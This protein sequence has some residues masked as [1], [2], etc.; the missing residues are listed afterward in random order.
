MLL[1]DKCVICLEDFKDPIATTCNHK[2]CRGCIEKAVAA[3]PYCP[4]CKVA[5]RAIV[6][7]QPPNGEMTTHVWHS[8][9][10]SFVL[11]L[12]F[13]KFNF[14]SRYIIIHCLAM[15]VIGPSGSLITFLMEHRVKI[16]PI[17]VKGTAVA[18]VWPIFR[19]HQKDGKY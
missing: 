4:I 3:S 18:L 19:T 14:Y 10:L 15:K 11:A 2:F 1:G 13:Y 12:I 8:D 5:L 6:G 7:N 17:L 9:L 16:I